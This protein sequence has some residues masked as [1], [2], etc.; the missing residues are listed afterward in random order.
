MAVSES[1]MSVLLFN[2]LKCVA[3]ME[4]APYGALQ[5]VSYTFRLTIFGPSQTS[6]NHISGSLLKVVTI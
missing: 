6:V 2:K 1:C 3:F 4:N 5:G